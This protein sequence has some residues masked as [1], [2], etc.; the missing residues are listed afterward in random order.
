MFLVAFNTIVTSVFQSTECDDSEEFIASIDRRHRFFLKA[1]S[2]SSQLTQDKSITEQIVANTFSFPKCLDSNRVAFT[3]FLKRI[4]DDVFLSDEVNSNQGKQV[5]WTKVVVQTAEWCKRNKTY[6]KQLGRV[7][8]NEIVEAI[9][10]YLWW[11]LCKT[12]IVVSFI[13]KFF[14]ITFHSH[15]KSF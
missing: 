1:F 3:S 9:C 12:D 2:I 13:V 11:P 6:Y 7:E 14:S 10:W 8:M 4:K 15:S 5:I